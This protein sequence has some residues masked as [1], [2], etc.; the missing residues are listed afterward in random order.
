MSTASV[1]APAAS[2]AR[3]ANA[4]ARQ[5][6]ELRQGLADALKPED[7]AAIALALLVNALGRCR[8]GGG[9]RGRRRRR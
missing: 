2:R 7:F 5:V 3:P 4:F 8:G 1:Q 6:A 9:E